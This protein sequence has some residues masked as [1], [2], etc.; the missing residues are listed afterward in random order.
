MTIF[1]T[2]LLE[3]HDYICHPSSFH[4]TPAY[5]T[6]PHPILPHLFFSIQPKR[7]QAIPAMRFVCLPNQG[8]TC[9]KAAHILCA[10]LEFLKQIRRPCQL[11]IIQSC[12]FDDRINKSFTCY[13]CLICV[14]CSVHVNLTYTRLP[15]ITHK[16]T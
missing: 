10:P 7:R 2:L 6:T 14:S 8:S 15:L 11:I 13:R 12:Y 9:G 5:S 3:V 1:Q 4:P 16:S